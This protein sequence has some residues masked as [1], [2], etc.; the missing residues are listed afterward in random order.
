SKV[1]FQRWYRPQFTTL[2]V[3]GDVVPDQV[4]ALAEKYWG[5][6]EA[7]SSKPVDIPKEPAPKGPA[8]V[9]VPWP[10]DTLPYVT[11]AFPAPAFVE[12]SKDPAAMD[13]IAALYF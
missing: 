6:W 12:T 3:A 10:A 13:L 9:H 1:F 7:G 8:Y 4:I 5:G 11:V 2:I